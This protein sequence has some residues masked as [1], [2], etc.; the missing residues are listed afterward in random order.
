MVEIRF[1]IYFF[2]IYLLFYINISTKLNSNIDAGLGL[3]EKGSVVLIRTCI[4]LD[5]VTDN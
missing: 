2:F 1:Y 5:K 4:L 3:E